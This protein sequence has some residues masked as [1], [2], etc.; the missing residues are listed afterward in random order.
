MY[1]FC[2]V[3][4]IIHMQYEKASD[5]CN[6]MCPYVC[7]VYS[8]DP[9]WIPGVHACVDLYFVSSRQYKNVTHARVNSQRFALAW[10]VALAGGGHHAGAWCSAWCSGLSPRHS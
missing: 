5:S 2:G 3:E 6:T 10:A 9:V 4:V 8:P 1:L 7:C